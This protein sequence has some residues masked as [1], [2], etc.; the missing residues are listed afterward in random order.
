MSR[1]YLIVKEHDKVFENLD[2]KWASEGAIYDMLYKSFYDFV[3][4]S[5]LDV[6]CDILSLLVHNLFLIDF[7]YLV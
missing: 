4:P 5:A 6:K 3:T 7:L 2:Q 1:S